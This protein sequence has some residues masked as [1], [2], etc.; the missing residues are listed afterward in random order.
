MLTK[1]QRAQLV[2]KIKGQMKECHDLH[3]AVQKELKGG[4]ISREVQTDDDSATLHDGLIRSAAVVSRLSECLK[5]FRKR[6]DQLNNGWD[7]AC[8]DCGEEI[9]FER[10]LAQPTT[11][12][13]ITCKSREEKA[14]RR[15]YGYL[16]GHHVFMST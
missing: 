15:D 9:F 4:G 2:D 10:L 13:C 7:G 12:H 14:E 1:D 8:E 5:K 11:H 3:S 6:L 16:P